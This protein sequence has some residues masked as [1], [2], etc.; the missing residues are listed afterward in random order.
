MIDPAEIVRVARSMIGVP[1]VHQGR[2]MAGM[3][4]GGHLCL[5]AAMTPG[6]DPLVGVP[7]NYSRRGLVGLRLYRLLRQLFNEIPLDEAA[8]GSIVV[9]SMAQRMPGKPPLPQHL[10]VLVPDGVVHADGATGRVV[11]VPY[12]PYWKEKEYA[13]FAFRPS[14]SG[15]AHR[16]EERCA[17]C[18]DGA[19]CKC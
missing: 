18:R 17:D 13:A 9:W 7:A 10:G 5:V 3:D 4:C 2:K 14:G 12:G 11:E 6:I 16:V 8:P 15:S 1:F 19:P